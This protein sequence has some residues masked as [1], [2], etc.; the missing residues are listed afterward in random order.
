MK[1]K[2]KGTEIGELV[3]R[4]NKKYGDSFVKSG[5]IIRIFYPNGIEPSQYDDL[6]GLLRIL[7]KMFRIATDKDA[8]G[9]DPWEDIAGYGILKAAQDA[10]EK[11]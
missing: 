10:E 5:D 9:E 4:K 11:E 8:L 7:D 2:E 1:Y 3:E 6:L